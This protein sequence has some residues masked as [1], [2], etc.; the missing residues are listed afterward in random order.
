VFFSCYYVIFDKLQL[1]E[2]LEV[3]DPSNL[4]NIADTRSLVTGLNW[5]FKQ[6]DLKLQVD[7]M[8]SSVPGL[9]DEQSKIIARLQT[10]F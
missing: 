8:R 1:V 7:W 9:P 10:V 2:R 3:F 5:Y 6:H 4:G